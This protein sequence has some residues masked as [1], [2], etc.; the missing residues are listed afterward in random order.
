MNFSFAPRTSGMR[1]EIRAFISK[2]LTPALIDELAGAADESGHGPLFQDFYEQVLARGWAAAAWPVAYGGQGL[3]VETQYV[4][5]EEF[6]RQGLRIGGAGT[7]AAQ[8]LQAGTEVQRRHYIPRI[9]RR[10]ARFAPALS[11][12]AAGTDLAGVTCRAEVTASG[13]YRISGEKTYISGVA[14]A[15]HFLLVAR[16]GTDISRGRGLS[17]FMVDKM[18]PGIATQSMKTVQADPPAPLGTVFGQARFDRILLDD[19]EV[20]GD[21]LLGTENDGWAVIGNGTAYERA[22]PRTWMTAVAR[23]E[24]F[25]ARLAARPQGATVEERLALGMLWAEGQAARLLSMRCLG[26]GRGGQTVGGEVAMEGVWTAE[27]V[28]RATEK[29]AQIE[30]PQAQMLAETDIGDGGLL[31]HSLLG[32]PQTATHH[33]GTRALRDQIAARCLNMKE[34]R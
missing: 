12:P 33:G 8:I 7:A 2:N 31:A 5:E 30:G 19:C 3:D 22:N 16:T 13:N 6:W 23:T 10:E 34:S 26:L 24:E 20:P 4:I 9:I 28:I 25:S 17:V 11:E 29:I 27:Y 18:L 32:A 14:A 21:C 15:T 1:S